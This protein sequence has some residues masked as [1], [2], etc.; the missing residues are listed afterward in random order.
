VLRA[1]NAAPMEA[2]QDFELIMVHRRCAAKQLAV[3]CV[4]RHG[5][6]RPAA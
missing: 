5:P 1:A 4:A 3:R 2:R 6:A